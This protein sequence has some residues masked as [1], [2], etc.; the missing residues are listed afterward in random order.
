MIDKNGDT[1]K[2]ICSFE[3]SS[4]YLSLAFDSSANIERMTKFNAHVFKWIERHN[5]YLIDIVIWFSFL[6]VFS[7]GV[8]NL[9]VCCRCHILWQTALKFLHFHNTRSIFITF[10]SRHLSERYVKRRWLAPAI[11]STAE[12]AFGRIRWQTE[13]HSFLFTISI[14][15]FIFLAL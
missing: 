7:D 4:I 9:A 11:P 6:L 13:F 14:F 1:M 12:I 5:L 15:I 8:Q 2:S 3:N 10:S